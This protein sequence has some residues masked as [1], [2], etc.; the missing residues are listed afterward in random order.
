MNNTIK[1]KCPTCGKILSVWDD[2][3]NVGKSVRCPACKEKH[4]FTEFKLVRPLIDE[5]KTC[6]GLS[7]QDGDHTEL[8]SL[9]KSAIG[10]LQNETDNQKYR[11]VEGLNLIGRKTYQQESLATIPIVTEDRGFSRKH[12]YIEVVKGTDGI[13]RHYAYNAANKNET[14]VNGSPLVEGDKV[15]LHSGDKIES[16][17]TTLIFNI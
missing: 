16:S 14:R 12:L 9:S 15:I 8:P 1:I 3:S 11:L 4:R 10:F 2:P 5:D 17:K 6:I 13:F 7:I